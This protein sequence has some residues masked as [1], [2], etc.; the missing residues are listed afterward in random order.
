ME[1][2]ELSLLVCTNGRPETRP[3][4][5]MGVQLAESLRVPVSLLGVLEE[6][7]ESISLD[8]CLGETHARMRNAAVEVQVLRQEGN[9]PKVIAQIA[10]QGNFLTIVGPLGRPAWRRMVQGRSFRRILA[11][12]ESPVLYV[13]KLRW[14]IKRMLL[15][16]G[17]LE[18]ALGVEHVGLFLARR[19]RA[20]VTVMHVVEPVTLDY[21]T[22]RQV[23]D[24]WQD[25]LETD[26][27]QGRNLRQ[28]MT[29]LQQA[30][31]EVNFLVRHGNIIHEILSEIQHG[32]YELIGMGSP[33][34]VLN[35]FQFPLDA[36]QVKLEQLL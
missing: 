30:G 20:S 18:Y 29:D 11:Q 17:G 26:T 1:L 3:A 33:Y 36:R 31:V 13:P 16:M 21:P 7:S 27:P 4:L 9:L 24:H 8:Q 19:L 12:V 35:D 6:G 28:A 32:G 22:S 5:E 15:C 14:P 10:N 34:S 2:N 25:I 23:H